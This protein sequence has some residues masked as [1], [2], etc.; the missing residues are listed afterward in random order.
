MDGPPKYTRRHGVGFLAAAAMIYLALSQE[1]L[2]PPS[3]FNAVVGYG[4]A[5]A[6]SLIGLAIVI[7]DF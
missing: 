5:A 1:W 2:G 6:L 3:P 7:R 4:L